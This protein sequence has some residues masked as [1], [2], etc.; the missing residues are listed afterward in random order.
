MICIAGVAW[1]NLRGVKESGSLFAIPTYAFVT[2]MVILIVWGIFKTIGMHV[3]VQ[4][5]LA[6]RGEL[7]K[8][9]GFLDWFLLLRAFAAGCTALTGVE[10]VSDGV[11]AFKE[12]SA[13]NAITTL[14]WMSVILLTLFLGLGY[15]TRYLPQIEM[16]SVTNK[17]FHHQ[18]LVAQ[19]ALWVQN[20]KDG[21]FFYFIQWST[22]AILI[23]A[24][25]TA[26]ADFPRL[27][28]F[29]ARDGFLPRPFAR[30][31]DR[32]VFHN[33][34]ILLAL[35]ASVLVWKFNGAL[36]KLLPLYAV[37]V[38]TAFTLS[39]LA[40][41]RHWQK[42]KGHGWQMR[43][44]ISG[45]GAI[46]TFGVLLIIL[47]TKFV[48]GAWI[49]TVLLAILFFIFKAI[50]ARYDEMSRQLVIGHGPMPKRPAGHTSL[51]LVPR[52][53][54]G[55][56]TALEY[57]KA[58]DPDCEAVHVAIDD[59]RLPETQAEWEKYG[60]GVPLVVLRSPY[61]SLIEPVLDYVDELM[62]ESPDQVITVIVPEAVS[63]KWYQKLLQENVAQQLKNALGTRENVVVT[64]VKYF[65]E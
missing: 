5:I 15:L 29:M 19:I 58:T 9:A 16:Y 49:V 41:F 44:F 18:T 7:H 27:S 21:W 2:G 17:M 8:E 48:E 31:G 11:A 14:R 63:T 37:G 30:Q 40:M 33:G 12:P 39:Q 6:D 53:H 3:P 45:A 65:L 52:V 62:L 26:F 32:L 38:F 64:N 47:I 61:R 46:V 42:E 57:A 60:Q 25:N 43:A 51:L 36:E 28:S 13:T 59:R 34:I 35:T 24:A 10:A 4:Q 55:I 1:A 56:L 22:A 20:G 50:R 54:K 23:L